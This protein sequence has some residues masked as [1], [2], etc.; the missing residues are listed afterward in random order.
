[1]S[2]IAPNSPLALG[3]YVHVPF[4]ARRC[5]FCAFYEREPRRADIARYMDGVIAELASLGPGR[6]VDTVFWGGGT[7]GILTP[8][9]MERLGRAV[10]EVCGGA[11]AEWTVEMTPGTMRRDRMEVLRNMGV[12]RISMGVQSF[13]GRILEALGRMHTRA[14]VYGA[15]EAARA[16][17]FDNLNLDMMFAL[18]G[19]E[20]AHWEADLREAIAAG[21][22]H[23]STYCLT[24]EEDT[25]LWL[26]L[27]RGQTRKR[28]E[29]EEAEYYERT[30]DI[31]GT[32][33]L[34]QYEVSNFARAGRECVHNL[35]TW[36]MQEW[37]GAGPS[38]SSQY[39]GR[40]FTNVP[41][42]DGWLGGVKGGNPELVDIVELDGTI[43]AC[44]SLLF[45]LRMVRGVD[46]DILEA[47]FPTHDWAGV[48]S[49]AGRL[50]A[51]GLAAMDGERLYLTR[52]GRLLAD[53]V[54]AEFLE[55][56]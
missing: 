3:L 11:P 32:A 10:L 28:G 33:G 24:F 17:G 22:E 50:C 27:N 14:Q 38:A 5:D 19:Q 12:N 44:D 25:P 35:N 2:N 55:N 51:E 8:S 47:R 6:R 46:L 15:I 9:D 7:P 37:L 26:R 20:F 36:R 52:Q 30:W 21:P 48:R 41:S 40:R 39:A 13:D 31:L 45:G 29:A 56:V 42:L 23:I 16:A 49:L 43:L 1:M 34:A 18:P 4:C 53:S 54:G